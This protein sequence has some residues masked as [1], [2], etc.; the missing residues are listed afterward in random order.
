MT[1]AVDSAGSVYRI[2][3]SVP[4]Y[5]F[6]FDFDSLPEGKYK[7]KGAV[8]NLQLEREY[9]YQEADLITVNICKPHKT[10][11]LTHYNPIRTDGVITSENGR[12]ELH[13][14][15]MTT[16]GIFV[17]DKQ[18]SRIVRSFDNHYASL[19]LENDIYFRAVKVRAVKVYV[20]FMYSFTS[21]RQLLIQTENFNVSEI[22]FI[23]Y[24][25]MKVLFVMFN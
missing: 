9:G 19:V 3:E 1:S 12:F 18:L 7:F 6:Y 13:L 10:P 21:Y 4:N 8:T 14:D 23:F 17:Y 16:A 5:F 25:S 15:K 24:S 20:I 2:E 11:I 22:V